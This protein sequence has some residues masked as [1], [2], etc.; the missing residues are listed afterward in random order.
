[1]AYG[2]RRIVDLRWH[3]E[4]ELDEPAAV[5]V[6]VVH[7]PPLGTVDRECGALLAAKLDAT[8]DTAEYFRWSYLDF[9]ER[10]HGS[11]RTYLREAGVPDEAPDAI[12]ERLRG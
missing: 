9:L 5:P 11:A 2:A 3:E 4:L 8:E 6:E 10:Y 1:M 7:V 12:R